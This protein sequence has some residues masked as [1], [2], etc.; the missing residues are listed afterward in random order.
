MFLH[1]SSRKEYDFLGGMQWKSNA[2]ATSTGLECC[3][4]SLWIKG[5]IHLLLV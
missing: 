1:L 2:D 4:F 5:K 3:D